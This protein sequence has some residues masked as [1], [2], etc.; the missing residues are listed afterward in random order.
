MM[1]AAIGLGLA[2]AIAMPLAGEVS[3]L[4]GAP[5]EW[6]AWTLLA[7]CL[8]LY[9]VVGFAIQEL[10][11]FLGLLGLLVPWGVWSLL[12]LAG[13]V[14]PVR[15]ASGRWAWYVLYVYALTPLFLAGV[16]FLLIRLR[17]RRE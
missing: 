5:P 6:L 1:G 13:L 15:E 9:V 14:G 3:K 10:M 7:I 11:F 2:L 17:R 12:E 4:P 16:F 8:V